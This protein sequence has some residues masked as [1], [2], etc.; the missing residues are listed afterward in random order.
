MHVIRKKKPVINSNIP[1][2]VITH[3][4]T[5]ESVINHLFLDHPLLI[6]K[7]VVRS[8]VESR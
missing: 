1:V 8:V 3:D 2:I 4:A 5:V 6:H 7:S